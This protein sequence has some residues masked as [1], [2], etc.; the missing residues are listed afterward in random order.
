MSTVTAITAPDF[1]LDCTDLPRLAA[2]PG[3]QLELLVL[4][5][6]GWHCAG[7]DMATGVLVRTWSECPPERRLRPYDLVRVTLAGE[8]APELPDPAAPEGLALEGAPEPIGRLGSRQAERLLRPLLHPSG[9]PLLGSFG[10]TV[11]FWERCSDHPSVALV[12]PPGPVVLVRQDSY[13]GCRF[14]WQDRVRE[15]P[16]L[17]RRV[18]AE[19]DRR[20]RSRAV[21]EGRTRLLVALTQPLDGHCRKV[22]EAVLPRP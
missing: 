1:R 19:L 15:L 10:P 21:L 2:E 3:S 22:V 8:E 6:D 11:P 5:A 18:A 12:E 13:L 17:D 9:A 16:C 7:V 4:A 14:P 20:G